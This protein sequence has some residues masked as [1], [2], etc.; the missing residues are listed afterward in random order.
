MTTPPASALDAAPTKA[1]AWL[2]LGGNLGNAQQTVLDAI[3]SISRTPHITL[4]AASS[5]YRSAPFEASGPD[6]INAV[7]QVSTTLA[8]HALLAVCQHI[9]NA[10]GRQRPYRNAPRTLDI[11]ILLYGD[12][13]NTGNTGNA[14]RAG[15]ATVINTPALTLP[16]PRMYQRAFVLLPLAEIAPQHVTPA[17][18][19]AVADQPIARLPNTAPICLV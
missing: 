1:T 16:H 17:Q 14:G 11:D 15:N 4:Q 19:Q 18:L 13:G 9:E 12:V 5:L 8:P 3:Q 6:F 2:A 7:V 10:A